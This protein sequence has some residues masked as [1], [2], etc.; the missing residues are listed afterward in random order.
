MGDSGR[1]SAHTGR[2]PSR[3]VL[4]A[5]ATAVAIA[6]TTPAATG[7]SPEG[8]RIASVEWKPEPPSTRLVTVAPDGSG[9]RVLPLVGVQPVQFEGPVWSAD[10]ATLFF[11]GYRVDAAGTPRENGRTRI[12][13]VAAE[14]GAPQPVPGTAGGSHPVL[15]PDGGSLAFKRS[16]FFHRFN[17]KKPLDFGAYFSVTT[18]IVPTAGGPRRQ[19]TPWRDGL[20]N[21]PAAFSP[22]GATLLLERD[23]GPGA[24]AEIVSRRLAGGPPR[25]LFRGAEDPAY[26]P[27]GSRIAFVSYRD[28]NE[29]GTA[30]G[31]EP[32]SE[33][34]VANADGSQPRRLT[35]T[36]GAQESQPGWAP[37]GLRLAFLRVPGP[38]GL[39]FGSLLLQ[40]NSDGSCPRRVTG[41]TARRAAALYGPAWQ[42][43]P[44]REPGPLIC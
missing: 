29:V 21:E 5:V 44:G 19:L 6:A 9:R 15:S 16:K 33:L 2:V 18:W 22:D 35:R 40:A 23:R 41:A 14:G 37:G 12:F 31:P 36:P 42:P 34:Y 17:P 27:D 11:A 13:A 20:V 43:G 4:I 8:P 1:V 24:S 25:V 30:E 32:V 7:A 10:G 38:G 26:S 28:G 3:L 39:G